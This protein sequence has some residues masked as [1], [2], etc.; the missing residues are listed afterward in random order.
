MNSSI[1]NF[2]HETAYQLDVYLCS[3]KG[4]LL[5]FINEYT[6]PVW[7]RAFLY[8]AGLI[9]CFLGVAIVADIFMCSIEKIT[10][11]VRIIKVASEEN[12][13]GFEEVEVKVRVSRFFWCFRSFL[14]MFTFCRREGME[15]HRRQFDANGSRVQCSRNLAGMHR[16]CW[17][18][19]C[20]RWF[21]SWNHRWIGSIQSLLHN[22][23]VRRCYSK[24]GK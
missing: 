21:R 1:T 6:W 11:H 14:R 24:S 8:F 22:G 19:F 13:Q 9:W 5:P 18:R 3:D 16:N 4:L 17:K 12:P 20:C 15:R 10:S 23:I 7:W 2:S